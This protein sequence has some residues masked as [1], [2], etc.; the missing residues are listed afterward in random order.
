MPDPSTSAPPLLVAEFLRTLQFNR[1]SENSLHSHRLDLKKFLTWLGVWDGDV[2]VRL[3]TLGLD[4]LNDYVAHLQA[5][6]K[7]RTVA[8][9][10]SSLKLFLDYVDQQGLISANP[11]HRMRFPEIL[12]ESPQLL[13]P[14]EVVAF[15]EAPSPEHYL[16]LRDR[17]MLELLYS[18]GLKVNELL[19]LDVEDLFLDLAFLKVRARRERMVPMTP[20][21]V[22]ALRD[23]LENGRAQRLT[24]PHD[25]CLFP[26]R[27]GTRMG[28][29]GFWALVRKYAQRAG[30]TSPLNPRILRHSF[31]A[32][33]LQNGM[34]LSDIRDLFG[35]VSLDAT[36][37]YAHINRPDYHDAYH[38][39]HPR[40]RNR[41]LLD[42]PVSEASGA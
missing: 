12:S 1:Y 18:S 28:R 17:A 25:P 4:D 38:R 15:L 16:G 9:H 10:L 5:S 21:A 32:H 29:V 34:D 27:N 33:L 13:T 19:G 31:A 11:V 37:Q 30:I 3:R 8:R 6:L 24:N 7:P 41:T 20:V 40:G 35:Y 2:V 14:E 23:Y 42:V 26:G 22:A 39:Y 36:L